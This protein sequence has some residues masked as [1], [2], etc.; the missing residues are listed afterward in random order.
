M[1]LGKQFSKHYNCNRLFG[2]GTYAK[3]RVLNTLECNNGCLFHQ[4]IKK[5]YV[6]KSTKL[7]KGGKTLADFFAN[8]VFPFAGTYE[9]RAFREVPN[10]IKRIIQLRIK[11]SN[12]TGYS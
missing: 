3:W 10:T 6:S 1:L 7:L 8:L 12:T 5:L 11:Q 9:F 4:H 2:F